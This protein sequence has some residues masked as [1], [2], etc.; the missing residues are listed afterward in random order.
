MNPLVVLAWT[1][2]LGV[3]VMALAGVAMVTVS[4]IGAIRDML[5]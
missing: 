4:A 3:L 2:T 1:F 5:R